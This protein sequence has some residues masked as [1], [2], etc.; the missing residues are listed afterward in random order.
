MSTHATGTYFTLVETARRHDPNGNIAKIA[1]VL[2]EKNQILEDAVFS[3]ANNLTNHMFTRRL[4]EPSGSWVNVNEGVNI[5]AS[6]TKQLVEPIRMLESYSR[7]DERIL[8]I[9]KNKE[10]FRSTEDMAFVEGLGKTFAES[11]FYGSDGDD[12][13]EIIGLSNR[14]EWDSVSDT[15]YVVDA[16]G[17]TTATTFS[18]WIIDWGPDKVHMV[19]PA[20]SASAGIQMED[21]GKQLVEPSSGSLYTAYVTRFK[22]HTGLVIRDPRC[23]QRIASCE[24]SSSTNTLTAEYLIEAIT[25]MPDQRGVIYVNKT[26]WQK[27]INLAVDK[28]NV[29][30]DPQ[31]PW[32]RRFRMD[33]MGLPVKLCEQLTNTETM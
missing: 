1:E 28:V 7:I 3:E 10:Q 6:R 29:N 18:A 2:T 15:D 5:E 4:T 17:S 14:S 30:Y 13:S 27:L 22:M 33:F 12:P 11:F 24:P 23:I 20:G 32:G 19:Y 16:G 31:D 8:D 9:E 21:L 25:Q 26:G